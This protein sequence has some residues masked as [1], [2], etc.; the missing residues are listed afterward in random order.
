M[1]GALAA[2]AVA[3]SINPSFAAEAAIGD[4]G[5]QGIPADPAARAAIVRRMRYRTD[6]GTFMW[7]FRG[8]TYAQQGATLIPVCGLLFGSMIKL[9]PRADGGFDMVQYELGFRTDLETG[10]R[11]DKLRNPI[12]GEML[13]IKAFPVGPTKLAYAADNVPV[14]PATI[15]G[16][17]F[18]YEHKPELFWTAGDMLFMQY[19][20][21]S[22]VETAGK[23]DRIINDVGMIYGKLADALNPRVKSAPAWIQG[24][25]V[26]DYARWLKMPEGSG[27]QT[28]RSIGAKVHRY[29][30][31]PA[32]WRAAVAEIDP[33]MAADPMGVFNRNEETYRG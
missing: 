22:K 14:V 5:A 17:M 10:K 1:L 33:K 13:E 23:P 8:R 3:T 29:A 31:M 12:T 2:G 4:P 26:T 11:L 7:W 20:A 6:A 32:D 18:T 19:Q 9:S 16:S 24:T 28:L 21:R 25:D 27:T 15:G 30:D